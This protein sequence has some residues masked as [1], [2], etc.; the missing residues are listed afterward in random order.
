[1]GEVVSFEVK[2]ISKWVNLDDL[3]DRYRC[4]GRTVWRWIKVLGFPKPRIKTR[5]SLWAWE[6]VIA[7]ENNQ[8]A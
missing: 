3:S 5:Q 8:A 6:D 2:E 1:M 4:S 7:W